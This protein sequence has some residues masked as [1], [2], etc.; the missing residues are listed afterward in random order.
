MIHLIDQHNRHRYTKELEEHYRIRHKIYVTERRWMALE[1]PDQREIDQFDTESTI[2]LLALENG[3]VVGGTRLRKTTEPHLMQDVFPFL[4]NVRGLQIGPHIVEWTRIFVVDDK[5]GTPIL[6]EVLAGMLEYCLRE[7]FSQI[8]VVME[9]WWMPRFLALGWDFEPLGIPV[10]YDGME[11]VA[12]SINVSEEAYVQ[13]LA[14]SSLVG[15]LIIPSHTNQITSPLSRSGEGES[16]RAGVPAAAARP[17]LTRSR[18]SRK[19]SLRSD[20]SVM[21]IKSP[22]S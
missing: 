3:A 13:T 11:I 19:T 14:A 16:D 9:T 8:T 7:C 6:N 12:C 10:M 1:R 5:R 21:R 18:T 17:L 20:G 22:M 2:Y 4:P 15:P